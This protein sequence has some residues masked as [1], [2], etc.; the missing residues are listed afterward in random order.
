MT[1]YFIAFELMIYLL[2]V[3]CFVH[4]WRGGAAVV[5]RLLAGVFFGIL[6]EYGTIQQLHSYSYGRFLIML[7][8]VPLPIG[9]AWGCIVYS[10]RIFSESSGLPEW[11]RPLLSALFALNIDLSMDAIAIRLGFWN[12]AID[13]HSQFFGVPYGNF[14]A[15]FWVVFSFTAGLRLI[16]AWKH[17]LS[18]WL[19]PLG[20]MVSGVLVVLLTNRLI[21]SISAMSYS[22]YVLLV[23]LV[24]VGALGVVLFLRAGGRDVRSYVSDSD[25]MS[26]PFDSDA[27][28]C[29][30]TGSNSEAMSPPS[31]SDAISCVSTGHAQAAPST[32]VPLSFHAFFLLAG[33]ISG[34]FFQ[35]PALLVISLLMTV[36]GAY[37]HPDVLRMPQAKQIFRSKEN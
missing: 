21:V 30:S 32:W 16:L 15:W 9:V 28:S 17:P 12:W 25:A 2:F 36:I 13:I 26:P 27:I 23:V 11:A 14:W 20:A 34:I 29:V 10:A 3:L 33:A 37:M 6:L 8:D 24:L 4:A 18:A 19:A 22:L 7:G 35:V 31:H 1:P 5:W